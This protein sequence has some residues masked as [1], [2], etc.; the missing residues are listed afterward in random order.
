MSNEQTRESYDTVAERYAQELSDELQKKPF[1]R[2]LLDFFSTLLLQNPNEQAIV[3]DVGCGPGHITQYLAQRGLQ[4]QGIDLSP[5]MIE[6]AKARFPQGLFRVASMTDLGEKEGAWGGVVALYSII[7]LSPKERALAYRELFR[8]L[9]PGGWLL[10][11]FHVSTASLSPGES[12]H[13]AEWWGHSVS[14]DAYFLAPAEVRAGLVEAG[15]YIQMSIEREP[16][17]EIEYQSR[18]C[19]LLAQRRSDAVI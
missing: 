13:L 10:L 15:F 12:Y 6:V 4:M 9:R 17:P 14:L 18:R 2:S 16:W 7:H 3:G 19:Y 11:S 5:K 1:E 8:V